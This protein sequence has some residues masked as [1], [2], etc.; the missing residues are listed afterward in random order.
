MVLRVHIGYEDFSY[1]QYEDIQNNK[2]L[3]KSVEF[4][5]I[6]H[7]EQ[8]PKVKIENKNEKPRRNE[9]ESVKYLHQ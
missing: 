2:S 7:L 5:S 1:R 6:P 3:F 4:Y 8:L 9:V